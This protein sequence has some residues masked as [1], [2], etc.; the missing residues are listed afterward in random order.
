MGKPQPEYECPPLDEVGIGVQFEPLKAFRNAHLGLYWS[1]IR[2][3]YP[4]AEDQ[5]PVA[6]SK[7]PE[8]LAARPPTVTLI[9]T[10]TMP[11]RAW[12]LD[13]SKTQLVQVQNDHFIRNWR[14]ITGE[15]PY[16]RFRA[17]RE[18]FAQE[19]EGFLSFAKDAELGEIVVNQC[20]LN[21][22]NHLEPGAGWQNFGELPKAITLL[23]EV[24]TSDGL[25]PSP[26][27]IAC[28]ARYKIP[29]IR[30]RLRVT[31]A[32]G[33][34]GRDLKMIV[35]FSLA[36]RGTPSQNTQ[37]SI[38]AWFDEAHDWILIA[39]DELTGTTMHSLWGKKKP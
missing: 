39:F 29:D 34:R 23:R 6:H 24:P 25:L 12:F 13:Q 3:R 4:F 32:P 17:L 27:M 35:M 14:R 15:E 20:E 22:V 26:E 38:L 37:E 18:A 9:G 21:Y 33:F 2:E 31:A 36:A 28:E 30:G 10:P 16:P 1:R 8:H 5:V 11:A 7:E 19:W